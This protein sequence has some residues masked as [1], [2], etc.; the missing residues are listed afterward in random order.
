MM[1]MSKIFRAHTMTAIAFSILIGVG[2]VVAPVRAAGT[3][4]V[5][6]VNGTRTVITDL[7][8]KPQ[9]GAWSEILARKRLGV[10]QQT[11]YGLPPG[12][13]DHYEI[14]AMF[15]DGRAVTKKEQNFCSSPYLVTDW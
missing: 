12:P 9:G 8:L 10:R 14:R 4:Q 7:Q 5:A 15:D 13:C 6:I 11:T 3:R 2:I 1:N